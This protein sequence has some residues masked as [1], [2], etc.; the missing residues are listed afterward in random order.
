MSLMCLTV[1]YC[2]VGSMMGE[3]QWTSKTDFAGS[4][5]KGIKLLGRDTNTTGYTCYMQGQLYLDWKGQT[6][7]QLRNSHGINDTDIMDIFPFWLC[8]CLKRKIW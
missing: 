3:G 5:T 7:H 1:Y 2:L 6:M 8:K 4:K